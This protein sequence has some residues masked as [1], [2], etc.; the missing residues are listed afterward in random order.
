MD[1][2]PSVGCLSSQLIDSVLK[3]GRIVISGRSVIQSCFSLGSPPVFIKA[4]LLYP[5]PPSTPS[6]FLS[7]S[8]DILYIG[9]AGI[10]TACSFPETADLLAEPITCNS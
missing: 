7:L 9:K 4:C 6:L 8:P 5:I 1:F 10:G 3:Y 2:P